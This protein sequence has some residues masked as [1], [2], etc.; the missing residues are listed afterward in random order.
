M[1]PNDDAPAPAFKSLMHLICRDK[2]K[3][4]TLA[5]AIEEYG[6]Q[7]WDRF[8]RFKRFNP[9]EKELYGDDALR[10]ARVL[11]VL[12]AQYA[13]DGEPGTQSPVDEYDDYNDGQRDSL[14]WGWLETQMPDFSAIVAGAAGQPVEPKPK[15]KREETSDLNIIAVL[16]EVLLPKAGYKSEATLI[17]DLLTLGYGDY[18]G[19]SQRTLEK[20]FAAA[21]KSLLQ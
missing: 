4:E 10:Y 3:I 6:I 9:K 17:S 20:R 19:I 11:D 21:K 7:G 12:A 5:S 14:D 13:W 1:T 15:S 16:L 8:G 2:I 18:P